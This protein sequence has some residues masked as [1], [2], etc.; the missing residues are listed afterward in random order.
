MTKRSL[1]ATAY[2]EAG[3]AV[4]ARWQNVKFKEVS[5]LPRNDTSGHVTP[6]SPPR[7]FEPDVRSDE[8]SHRRVE[9]QARVML[10]G[11]AAEARFKGRH[12]WRGASSDLGQAVFLLHYICGSNGELEAYVKLIRIQ[13]R[14]LVEA[15][16]N[17]VQ[18]VAQALL[19]RERL[20]AAEV[21]EIIAGLDRAKVDE[22]LTAVA[23]TP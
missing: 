5:I 17:E 16:W 10:A 18:A 20:T 8:R 2:H 4:A 13:A 7:W 6:T 9:A 12:D 21:V 1:A 15:H 19:D 14:G 23:P 22:W 3:H 11:V